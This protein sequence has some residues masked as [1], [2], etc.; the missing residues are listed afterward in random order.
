MSNT[1][2][3]RTRDNATAA[4]RKMG[5]AKEDYDKF[6]TKTRDGLYVV[7][8]AAV[9]S[10][11]QEN[12][13][14]NAAAATIDASKR[15][16]KALAAKKGV[17]PQP[18]AQPGSEMYKEKPAPTPTP[19]APAPK[20]K[21]PKAEKTP[22]A[23]AEKP[24]KPTKAERPVKAEK[25]TRMATV[26]DGKPSIGA[27][28]RELVKAGKSNDEIWAVIQKEYNL[29]D[30]KRWYAAWYRADAKRKGLL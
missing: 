22:K 16:L 26:K 21:A 29:P 17:K 2:S 9:E 28:I 8:F 20:A 25:K 11:K 10:L 19:A 15:N 13:K 1:K 23:K 30:D 27:A 5:I 14:A 3:Y 6:I 12:D 4:L 18:A 24:I 7:D